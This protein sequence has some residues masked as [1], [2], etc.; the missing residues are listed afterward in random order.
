MATYYRCHDQSYNAHN[1]GSLDPR[2]AEPLR[3][4]VA[5]TPLR[6]DLDI[7]RTVVVP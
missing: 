4:L 5:V 6:T 3:T 7:S 1:W 2:R